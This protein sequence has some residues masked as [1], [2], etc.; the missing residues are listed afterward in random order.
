MTL[1]I[2]FPEVS[3]WLIRL[4][5][6]LTTEHCSGLKVHSLCIIATGDLHRVYKIGVNEDFFFFNKYF[7]EIDHVI[8]DCMEERL[9]KQNM[10]EYAQDV[11]CLLPSEVTIHH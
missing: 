8:M 1:P 2:P 3:I 6:R 7:M 11:G 5:P 10:V 9:V 4:G